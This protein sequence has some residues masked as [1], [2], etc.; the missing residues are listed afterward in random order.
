MHMIFLM[1]FQLFLCCCYFLAFCLNGIFILILKLHYACLR[2]FLL[3]FH[4]PF[5]LLL[6]LI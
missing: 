1:F 3:N 2:N 6:A 4:D 5:P